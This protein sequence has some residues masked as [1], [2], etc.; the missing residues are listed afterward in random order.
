MRRLFFILLISL[1]LFSAIE[2]DITKQQQLLKQSD[3]KKEELSDK[4]QDLAARI[5]NEKKE[6][7]RIGSKESELEGRLKQSVNDL[8]KL[9]SE[10]KALQNQESSLHKEKSRIERELIEFLA[11]DIS[12]N[13]VTGEI[14]PSSEYDMINQ[15]IFNSLTKVTQ[16]NITELQKGFEDAVK[17][18]GEINAR[19]ELLKERIDGIKKDKNELEAVKKE[20]NSVVA[21]LTKSQQ[22]YKG[23]LNEIT[24]RQDEI[25]KL[26]ETLKI[27]KREAEAPP[28]PKKGAPLT[29]EEK[30]AQA[31]DVRKIG[32]SYQ[33][34]A[35][36][37]YNGKKTIAPLEGYTVINR[38]GPY[39][40]PVYNIKIFNESVTL[41]PKSSDAQVRSVL[42]GVVVFARK[43]AVM[44][45]V[46][47][48]EHP[49]NLHTIYGYLSKIAPT[50]K[51]GVTVKEGYVIGRVDDRLMFEVTQ[52][53]RYIDP[54]ELFN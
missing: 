48:I 40:D 32:S 25:S 22:K 44:D 37:K 4:L 26:L 28:P 15:E 27:K 3:K 50:I 52:K 8:K 10:Q 35:T 36:A 5:V 24:K 16:E 42:G 39:F 49:N 43:T 14:K 51:Q 33:D 54:L 21:S 34:V 13:F 2:D 6:M 11:K 53:N 38:F 41:K 12:F 1:P 46:V 29:K 20:K 9:E 45:Q 17:K 30:D 7:D 47:I 18:I 19:L 31:G 23:E